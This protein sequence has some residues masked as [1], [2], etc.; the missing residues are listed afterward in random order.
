MAAVE[1]NTEEFTDVTNTT[2]VDDC[3]MIEKNVEGSCAQI[4]VVLARLY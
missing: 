4:Q 2:V 1:I 3:V